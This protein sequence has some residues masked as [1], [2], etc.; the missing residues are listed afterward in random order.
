[1]NKP[2]SYI[3][4]SGISALLG[5][6]GGYFFAKKKLQDKFDEEL[7]TAINNEIV[8]IRKS[9]ENRAAKASEKKEVESEDDPTPRPAVL[10]EKAVKAINESPVSSQTE[11]DRLCK[12]VEEAGIEI[13]EGNV[14][15]F[16]DAGDDEI[17]DIMGPNGWGSIG[18]KVITIGEYD[19]LPPYFSKFVFKYF[20]GDDT[21]IDE[22]DSIVD[23]IELMIGD[24]LNQWQDGPGHGVQNYMY[25][26]NGKL[27]MAI[28]IER[29]FDSYADWSGVK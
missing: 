2:I 19:Q 13:P 24:A 22:A 14:V 7:T 16:E 23:D 12:K 18:P 6:I 9:N 3:L 27:G 29:H 10:K 8:A 26:V 5:G 20:E 17:Q 4:V 11:Y 1:M 28:E 25:V 15:E 21:L